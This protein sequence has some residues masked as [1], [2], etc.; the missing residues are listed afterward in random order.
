MKTRTKISSSRS[1]ERIWKS[2]ARPKRSGNW[3]EWGKSVREPEI[4]TANPEA[5]SSTYGMQFQHYKMVYQ[6]ILYVLFQDIEKGFHSVPLN[7][8]VFWF[9]L[10]PSKVLVD[11]TIVDKS[12]K[13][14]LSFTLWYCNLAIEKDPFSLSIY[15]LQTVIVHTCLCYQR[16]HMKLLFKHAIEGEVAGAIPKS[17]RQSLEIIPR[18]LIY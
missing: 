5:R 17:L 10:N 2:S 6:C 12:W 8:F 16:L 3:I 9:E 4:Q 14:N 7:P 11:R 15:L 13:K 18:I 1:N